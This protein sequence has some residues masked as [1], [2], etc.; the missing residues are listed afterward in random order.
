MGIYVV[1]F[2]VGGPSGMSNTN[3][4]LEYF[5]IQNT[6][7]LLKKKVKALV[8]ACNSSSSAAFPFLKKHFHLPVV[9]VISPAVEEAAR[10]TV[11]GR[12]Q[13]LKE[14][15]H[16]CI[17]HPLM[18]FLPRKFGTDLHNRNATSRRPTGFQ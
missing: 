18:M 2:P 9:D 7:F 13:W 6:L 12:V 14:F 3:I 17:V 16:N 4:A 1:G 8:I 15:T 5:S 10:K 11:S